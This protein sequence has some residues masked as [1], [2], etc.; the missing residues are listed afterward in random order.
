MGR[1]RKGLDGVDPL[2][3]GVR[4][5]RT[6]GPR[7]VETPP[8]PGFRHPAGRADVADLLE[9]L[10]AEA[11]YGLRSVE[12]CRGPD[13]APDTA[14]CFGR[15]RAPGRIALFDVPESPWR[16][17]GGVAARDLQALERGGATVTVDRAA[18]T[19][20][21]DWPG[22]TLAAFMLCDVLLHEI[23][24]HVLQHRTG[25]RLVR[26]ARTRDHEAFAARFAER[27]RAALGHW[28]KAK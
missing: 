4:I 18:G 12:L 25:K 8:R 16:W 9:R 3:P 26:V 6:I 24:H 19:T 15:L 13:W 7:I 23:G 27:W 14:L 2:P 21:V 11:L 22:E 5:G 1:L 17:L 10:G 28:A 20:L